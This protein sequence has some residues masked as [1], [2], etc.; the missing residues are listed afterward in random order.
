M[1][2]EESLEQLKS[3]VMEIKETV[4]NIDR[5]L[6]SRKYFYINDLS[7]ITGYSRRFI[8]DNPWT[9]PNFGKS[10]RP[11]KK[12]GWLQETIEQYYKVPLRVREQEWLNMSE[13][14]RKSF[15]GAA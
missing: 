6:P 9:Q 2:I 3:E 11:G 5:R 13:A 8:V 7:T 12:K 10:D 1:V 4:G 15:R 14:Q